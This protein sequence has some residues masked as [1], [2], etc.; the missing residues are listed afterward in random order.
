MI[1]SFFVP[2]KLGSHALLK[3]SFAMVTKRDAGSS[4]KLMLSRLSASLNVASS[5]L[6]RVRNSVKS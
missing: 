5:T 2:L 4:E 1:S 6:R 3:A